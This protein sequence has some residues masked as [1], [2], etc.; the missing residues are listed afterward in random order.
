VEKKLLRVLGYEEKNYL[1]LLLLSCQKTYRHRRG[2]GEGRML[3][4]ENKPVGITDMQEKQPRKRK[5]MLGGAAE[6]TGGHRKRRAPK[7]KGVTIIRVAVFDRR[8]DTIWEPGKKIRCWQGLVKKKNP[9]RVP[10]WTGVG[11]D[12]AHQSKERI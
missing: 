6:R 12:F 9:T 5:K 2:L 10:R 4:S 7:G 1:C 3:S 11:K 8:H